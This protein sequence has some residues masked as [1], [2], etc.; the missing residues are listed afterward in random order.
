MSST[1]TAPVKSRNRARSSLALG[2]IAALL[3]AVSLALATGLADDPPATG[4]AAVQQSVV[5]ADGG[6]DESAVA[7][8]IGQRSSAGPDETRVAA[9]IAHDS[10]QSA[11][12]P[13]EAR[14]AAAI[15]GR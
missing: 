6:P 7:A 3:A 12:R 4:G 15:S 1:V 5:R 14:I 13:D 8:A 2:A 11:A 10:A 9:S